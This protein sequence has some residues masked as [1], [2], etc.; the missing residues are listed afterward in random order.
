MIDRQSYYVGVKGIIRNSSGQVLILQD[1][2]S[3]KWELPGGRIDRGGGIESSFAREITEEIK[4]ARLVHF[5]KLVHAA[6]GDFFVE[7]LHKLLLLFYLVETKLPKTIV[8]SQEHLASEWIDKQSL[9][10]YEIYGTDKAAINLVFS[11]T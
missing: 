1:S 8:L 3:K 7:N 10:K 11:I 2:G 4:G 9:D 6:Q 5:G